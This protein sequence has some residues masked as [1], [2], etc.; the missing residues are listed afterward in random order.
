M[1]FRY[2]ADVDPGPGVY[3]VIGAITEDVAVVKLDPQ[4]TLIWARV[5][6]GNHRDRP[7]ALAVDAADNV[8]TVGVFRLAVDFDPGPGDLFSMRVS[9]LIASFRSSMLLATSCLPD[10]SAIRTMKTMG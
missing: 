4:G 3:Q 9:D 6:A 8:Y 7:Y 2:A 10:N 5:M 1:N